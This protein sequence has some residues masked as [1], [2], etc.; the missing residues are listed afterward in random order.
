MSEGLKL[1]YKVQFT[2][3]YPYVKIFQGLEE[4][5]TAYWLFASL[6]NYFGDFAFQHI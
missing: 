6:R 4:K 3:P 5:R 1:K 2:G